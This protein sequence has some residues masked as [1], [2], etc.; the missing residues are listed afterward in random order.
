MVPGAEYEV[1]YTV[2]GGD[3]NTIVRVMNVGTYLSVTVEPETSSTGHI[4][5][6]I[7]PGADNDDNEY[8]SS[9]ALVVSVSDGR[10]NSVMKSLN[11]SEGV[12]K[13]VLDTYVV[14]A[15]AGTF[16]VQLNVNLDYD[17]LI[18]ESATWLSLAPASKA[19]MRVDEIEFAVETNYGDTFRVSDVYLTNT[20]G[21]VIGSFAVF[22]RAINADWEIDFVDSFMKQ[23]CTDAFDTNE[24]GILTYE[25]AAFVTDLSLMKDY[26]STIL[27]KTAPTHFNELKHFKSVRNIPDNMF[28][29]CEN[30]K[31][32]TL[33][34]GLTEIGA[35]AF[36]DCKS[37][38]NIIFPMSLAVIGNHAFYNTGI[39]GESVRIEDETVVALTI[40]AS[41]TV[42]GDSAFKS[43]KNLHAV[44]MMS[45]VPCTCTTAFGTN[46]EIYVPDGCYE[47]Y[48]S[49]WDGNYYWHILGPR[50]ITIDGYPD[51]W[52]AI[53]PSLVS[54]AECD[55]DA[56]Y[57]AL[58]VFKVYADQD[59]LYAYVEYDVEM[60]DFSIVPFHLFFNSDGDSSTGGY[61]GGM[62]LTADCDI[63]LEGFT[64]MD[65][66]PCMWDPCVAVWTGD[67]GEDGWMW[68]VYFA[69]NSGLSVSA[70]EEGKLEMRIELRCLEDI[71]FPLAD[72]FSVSAEIE[73]NWETVGLLPNAPATADNFR[74]AADK[75]EVVINYESK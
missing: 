46:T 40:P 21:K 9:L 25:E 36:M 28:Y 26:T 65:G 58:H 72:R 6:C 2:I 22:Q 3:E 48:M 18:P 20:S 75:L 7:Q 50:L 64:Y 13:S 8:H 62:F 30:L 44:R 47:Q 69:E 57:T 15:V 39:K 12:V 35:R 5:I 16:S 71:G 17:I 70:G 31:S 52:D 68:D 43:C 42:I 54:V 4:V 19:A 63:M 38:E 60:V 41:V 45:E 34:S 14:D 11:I 10:N 27:F 61:L 24:D 74:G 53:D 67:N 33:P 73:C 23:L 56:F 49:A 59:Y 55:A 51:D 66:Y 29:G 1:G 37:L 32:V